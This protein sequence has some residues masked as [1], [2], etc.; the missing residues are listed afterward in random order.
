MFHQNNTELP[1]R[2]T[3]V[4]YITKYDCYPL[5]DHILF[6][7]VMI[8]ISNIMVHCTVVVRSMIEHCEIGFIFGKYK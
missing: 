8:D 3:D 7:W 1:A 6:I 4:F 2:N 5:K